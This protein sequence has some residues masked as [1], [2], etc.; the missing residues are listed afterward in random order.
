MK[1]LTR[2]NAIRKHCL[3]C[4]GDSALEVTLCSV[5]DCPLWR[6]R[7]GTEPHS[8]SYKE[9]FIRALSKDRV[10]YYTDELKFDI[11]AHLGIK[12]LPK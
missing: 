4:A 6:Y 5:L 7:V 8:K 11:F 1:R 10:K 2:G 3:E 12:K 9:R